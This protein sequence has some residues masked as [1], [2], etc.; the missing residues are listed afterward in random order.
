MGVVDCRKSCIC[1]VVTNNKSIQDG[2][3]IVRHPNT[4]RRGSSRGYMH[5]DHVSSTAGMYHARTQPHKLMLGRIQYHPSNESQY[6]HIRRCFVKVV[7]AGVSGDDPIFS[8]ADRTVANSKKHSPS[9]CIQ[10]QKDCVISPALFVLSNIING[11][12]RKKMK[13]IVVW[14]ELWGASGFPLSPPVCTMVVAPYQIV[15]QPVFSFT[16]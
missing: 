10:E 16:I 12:R 1:A 7:P 8:T 4:E 13:R 14:S 9:V 3:L 5:M 2:N 11:E 6:L 15:C